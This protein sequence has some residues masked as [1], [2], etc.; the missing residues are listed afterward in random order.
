MGKMYLNH[1][2]SVTRNSAFFVWF[3]LLTVIF[4]LAASALSSCKKE[5]PAKAVITVVDTLNNPIQGC[6]VE[7]NSENNPRPGDVKSSEITDFS[8]NAYFEFELEAILQVEVSRGAF[9]A[10]KENIHVIPG[11]TAEKTITLIQR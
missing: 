6:T 10:D 2:T 1:M 4:L 7:L 3:T 8:G 11:E 9:E 5:E